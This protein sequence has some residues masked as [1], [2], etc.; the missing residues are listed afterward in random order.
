MWASRVRFSPESGSP[1]EGA[2]VD[3][4]ARDHCAGAG[5]TT[6]FYVTMQVPGP[7]LVRGAAWESASG[8]RP[9]S[10]LPVRCSRWLSTTV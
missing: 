4:V 5:A 1:S 10:A 9:R 2:V 8:L 6:F 3:G 7:A